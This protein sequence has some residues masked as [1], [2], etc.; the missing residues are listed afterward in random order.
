MKQTTQ[1]VDAIKRAG[2]PINT[3][4]L[5]EQLPHISRDNISAFCS[6]LRKKGKL[7]GQVE[8]G[9][10][11]FTIAPGA[12][13]GGDDSPEEET[14]A[15]APGTEPRAG[16][17][18]GADRVED[19]PAEKVDAARVLLGGRPLTESEPA[20]AVPDSAEPSLGP[21]RPIQ[22]IEV[23]PIGVPAGDALADE[24]P[25]TVEPER[26][27]RPRLSLTDATA[28]RGHGAEA[29]AYFA[30]GARTTKASGSA[31]QRD[32]RLARELAAAVLARWPGEIPYDVQRLVTSAASLPL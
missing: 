12:D 18:P 8:E 3:A 26:P 9:R 2:Y 29:F 16:D 19:V 14:P 5:A 24:H 31:A 23:P 7:I 15:P 20:T 10:L 28:D 4:Q 21:A 11:A 32:T 1:I 30:A 13:L 25:A 27:G 22:C 17:A 6:Q